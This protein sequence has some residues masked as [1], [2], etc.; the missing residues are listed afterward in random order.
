VKTEKLV[1]SELNTTEV[2][3][4]LK[5]PFVIH[6]KAIKSDANDEQFIHANCGKIVLPSLKIFLD[7]FQFNQ[8][9]LCDISTQDI[10]GFFF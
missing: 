3:R 1:K 7:N 5:L 10:I 8:N 2:N 9:Q 4:V 6:G